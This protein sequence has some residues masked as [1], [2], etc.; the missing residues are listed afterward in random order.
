MARGGFY[1]GVLKA[2]EEAGI[3]VD[4]IIGSSIGALIGGLYAV[5]Y[6]PEDMLKISKEIRL[7]KMF[8]FE[9]LTSLAILGHG[10]TREKLQTFFGD[11]NFSDTKI[12]LAIQATN[13]TKCKNVVFETGLLVDVIQASIA[14]PFLL[15]AV[16]INGETYIDG[17]ITSGYAA[18]FLKKKGAE[19]VIGMNVGPIHGLGEK[20]NSF[21]NFMKSFSL[22]YHEIQKLSLLMEPVDLVID[23]FQCDATVFDFDRIEEM[24]EEGYRVTL[25]KIDK[26]LKLLKPDPWWKRI[27]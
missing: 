25:K 10:T 8:N 1:I 14:Y 2:F 15:K 12:K 22:A 24:A 6:S 17:D 13:L 5:G 3:Q 7:S 21:S 18:K 9:A 16:E 20:S 27:L 23:E 26:I 19:V 11:K 4:Y